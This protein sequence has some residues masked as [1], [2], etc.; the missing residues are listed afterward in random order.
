M[1]KKYLRNYKMAI[2]YDSTCTLI[3]RFFLFNAGAVVAGA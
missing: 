3:I 2:T 1:S